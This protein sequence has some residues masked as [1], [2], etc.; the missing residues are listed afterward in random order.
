MRLSIFIYLNRWLQ[1]QHFIL[2][3]SSKMNLSKSG[4]S[5]MWFTE[6]SIETLKFW[7]CLKNIGTT[8]T[9]LY[10]QSFWQWE[11]LIL[12]P[13]TQIFTW[14]VYHTL[15]SPQTYVITK[16]FFFP[17]YVELFEDAVILDLSSC[18]GEI[19]ISQIVL[20]SFARFPPL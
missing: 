19:P 11:W 9:Q 8:E 16:I 3:A 14:F 12:R 4:I 20:D 18:V 2:L 17:V 5:S 10:K 15:N 7:T 13:S 6:H 1:L